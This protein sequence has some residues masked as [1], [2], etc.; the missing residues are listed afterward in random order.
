MNYNNLDREPFWVKLYWLLMELSLRL[1]RFSVSLFGLW[2]SLMK[3]GESV[4]RSGVTL[5]S[6]KFFWS[7][8][9]WAALMFPRLNEKMSLDAESERFRAA[10]FW[11]ILNGGEVATL[12]NPISFVPYQPQDQ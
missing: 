12:P 7:I 9:I 8:E 2:H 3:L 4:L 10:C 1:T 6:F 11:W 5:Y